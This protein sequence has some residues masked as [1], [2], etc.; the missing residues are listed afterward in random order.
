MNLV[1]IELR[2]N[3]PIY[4][5]IVAQVKEQVIRGLLRAGDPIPS[6]RKLSVMTQVN[7]N[8]VAR[9]YQ[10]LERMEIIETVTGR[11]TFIRGLPTPRLEPEKIERLRRQLKPPLMELKLLGMGRDGIL[12]EVDGILQDL[13]GEGQ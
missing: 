7:P 3:Q 5:Q 8:T 12:R 13:E 10:E 4:E 1:D 11:G 2:S 6:I 9:A